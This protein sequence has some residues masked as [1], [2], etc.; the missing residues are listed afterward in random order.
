LIEKVLTAS[1]MID[2]KPN[3]TPSALEPLGPDEEGE[4]MNESWEYASILGMLMYLANNTRPDIAHAVHA[5]ARYTHAPKKSHATAVKHIL[6]YL[7]GTMLKGMILSPNSKH[8]LDCFVDSDFAGN[9]KYFKDQDPTSTKSRTGD[10]I[11]Y[12]GCPILWVSKLQT[13]CALSTMESE[14][15]ALSQ[16]MRD[17]IPLREILKEIMTLVLNQSE[18]PPKC[19][20]N[21]KSFDDIITQ[22]QDS[23]IPKSKVY[24]DN[25][26]CLKFARLPRLTPRTKHIAIPYHWFRSKVEQME[27][28]I[29]PISTE[30]QLADQFTKSLTL[31]KFKVAR[32]SL[33]GW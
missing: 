33:M 25:H 1:G 6:R 5:C 10:V 20:A 7:K 28:A 24:E 12:Q 11:M 15:L 16:S 13:Q 22:E 4:P 3:T 23:P 31:D 32:S 19:I 27:I 17:L 9:Y 21:S 8:E 26:A 18:S 30:N 14:Y 2:C 29:E